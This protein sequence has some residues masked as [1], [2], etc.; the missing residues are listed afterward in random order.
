MKT[1]VHRGKA[2]DGYVFTMYLSYYI[3]NV[4]FIYIRET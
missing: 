2:F 1:Y 3:P 4:K